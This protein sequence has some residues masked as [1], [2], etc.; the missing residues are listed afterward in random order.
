MKALLTLCLLLLL[1]LAACVPIDSMQST[2][3]NTDRLVAEARITATAQAQMEKMR[4]A[5]VTA[6]VEL[7]KSDREIKQAERQLALRVTENAVMNSQST[8]TAGAATL[9]A[10]QA[11]SIQQAVSGA[12]TQTAIGLEVAKAQRQDEIDRQQQEFLAWFI[13]VAVFVLVVLGFG[14]L[15]YFLWQ[16]LP[17]L[18]TWLDRRQSAIPNKYG[19]TVWKWNEQSQQVEPDFLA[20]VALQN[21]RY[22]NIPESTQL[23][24]RPLGASGM[25]LSSPPEKLDRS[26]QGLALRLVED[27]EKI[28]PPASARIPGHRELQWDSE[29][30]Q[31]V[32]RA[33]AAIGLVDG[34]QGKGTFLVGRYECLDDLHTALST[35]KL[36]LRPVP[37]TPPPQGDVLPHAE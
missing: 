14:T 3:P 24:V 11:T 10:G 25:V 17:S 13:P 6:A 28:E 16:L 15:F 12:A 37:R 35:G 32:I 5:T 18:I 26:T 33:L 31:K 22:R 9:Q 4:A 27:A 34:Q 30:W 2:D 29:P 1:S 36:I 23:S 8:A 21:V 7:D 20:T 19:I